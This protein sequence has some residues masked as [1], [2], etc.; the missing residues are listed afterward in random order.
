MQLPAGPQGLFDAPFH[1]LAKPWT[2]TAFDGENQPRAGQFCS[3]P[4][5][6]ARRRQ[7]AGED[8]SV[9]TPLANIWWFVE[10]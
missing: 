9:K 3:S 7:G 2:R 10:N 1:C 6:D 5:R 4:G 8:I